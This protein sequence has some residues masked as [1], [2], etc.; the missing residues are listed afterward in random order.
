M[1][2]IRNEAFLKAFGENV[3]KL[4]EEKNLSQEELY[5]LAGLSKN[6]IGNIE[7]GE[8]NTT[9]S[10]VYAISKALDIPPFKL[11]IF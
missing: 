5:D 7:R 9:L 6:Q 8:V 11:F 4:R 2:K 10:S 3:R 1:T